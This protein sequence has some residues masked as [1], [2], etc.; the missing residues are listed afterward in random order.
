MQHKKHVK[1]ETGRTFVRPGLETVT[2]KVLLTI[3]LR[4]HGAFI[5]LTRSFTFLPLK[6]APGFRS[7][8]RLVGQNVS[9]RVPSNRWSEGSM[10]VTFRSS[11]ILALFLKIIYHLPL[12]FK[13]VSFTF[14]HLNDWSAVCPPGGAATSGVPPLQS[15]TLRRR[16]GPAGAAMQN[17]KRGG[18]G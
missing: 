15:S 8:C 16:R 18:G 1:R 7:G 4:S 13:S 14:S 11:N 2:I 12:R 6:T 5:L 17:I 10:A 3:C 9:L